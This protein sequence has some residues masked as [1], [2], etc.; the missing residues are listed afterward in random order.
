MKVFYP[1]PGLIAVVLALW[2][3]G[4]NLSAA[5]QAERNNQELTFVYIHGFGGEKQSPQFC[6]NMREFLNRADDKSR[7]VNYRWDSVKVDPLRAGASWKNSQKR[8]DQEAQRFRKEIIDHLESRHSPYVLVGFSVG[9]RVIL[10]AL[11]NIDQPLSHLAGIYFLGSAMTR[12]TTLA[13][14]TALPKG[15]RIINYHSPLRDIV[16][17]TA[18]NFISAMPAGGQVG[19]DDSAVFE[20]RRVSC[21]HAYKG[22]GAHIDYSGLAG[23]IASLELYKRGI[24]IPGTTKFN[25][26]MRVGEGSMWWNRILNVRVLLDK[27]PAIFEIEQ[28][29]MRPGYFRAL[30]ISAG[31]NRTRIARGENLH[32]IL[33]KLGVE[34]NGA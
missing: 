2:F 9:S 34:C 24:R 33:E 8:A 32:A 30:R 23:A 16:H 21:A 31:G 14:S 15:M 6:K 7:V 20:N 4:I 3:S 22:V 18:F 10:R 26:V 1:G 13:D 12:D 25:V 29:N 17:S 11:E 19:F 28:H 5:E 27:G